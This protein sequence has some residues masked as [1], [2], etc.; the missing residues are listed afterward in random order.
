[1]ADLACCFCAYAPSV[2]LSLMLTSLCTGQGVPTYPDAGRFWAV[3]EKYAVNS[4]YTA[5]TAIRALKRFGDG[6]W[7]AASGCFPLS[8]EESQRLMLIIKSG[9]R[10]LHQEKANG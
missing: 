3:C 7:P 5:P 2:L 6:V 8:T 10:L 1:M 4:F 9:S